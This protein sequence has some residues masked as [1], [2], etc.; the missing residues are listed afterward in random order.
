MAKFGW[1][2][3]PAKRGRSG[4]AK[5]LLY[6]VAPAKN[7]V[8]KLRN[9]SAIFLFFYFSKSFYALCRITS[10]YVRS[11]DMVKLARSAHHVQTWV[12]GRSEATER[13]RTYCVMRCKQEEAEGMAMPN[14]MPDYLVYGV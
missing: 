13:N 3:D 5:Y 14:P 10:L 1:S 12:K 2:D 4:T 9:L 11:L 7:F 8:K 6:D